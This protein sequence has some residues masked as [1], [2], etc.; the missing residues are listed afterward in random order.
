M[1]ITGASNANGVSPLQTQRPRGGR[2]GF[3]PE[4]AKNALSDISNNF[5]TIDIDKDGSLSSSELETYSAASGLKTPENGPTDIT[6]EKLAELQSKI[7]EHLAGGGPPQGGPKGARGPRGPKPEGP[8]P[9]EESESIT[10]EES[11]EDYLLALLEQSEESSS[12]FG[13]LSINA[14]KVSSFYN[15]NSY[16]SSENETQSFLA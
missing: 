10:S 5:D 11:T 8:P 15:S 12:S 13:S 3:S 7:D 1:N 9:G 6:R 14:A 16:S 2:A 4:E